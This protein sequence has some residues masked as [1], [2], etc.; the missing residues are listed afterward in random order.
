MKKLTSIVTAWS[1]S[2]SQK[3]LT[4]EME[5][6]PSHLDCPSWSTFHPEC[7]H[8]HRL[9]LCASVCTYVGVSVWR[10]GVVCSTDECRTET[11]SPNFFL[12][13]DLFVARDMQPTLLDLSDFL[14]C[15]TRT[16]CYRIFV[17]LPAL[18][19]RAPNG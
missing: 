8:E 19:M 9:L 11:P 10:Q 2:G 7:V 17:V 13:V 16:L 1:W 5:H 4:A 6:E 14:S 3:S 15:K 18:A 12:T